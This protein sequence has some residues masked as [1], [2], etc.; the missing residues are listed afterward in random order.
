LKI[1]ERRRTNKERQR[2]FTELITETS[3]KRYGCV[4]AW[5]FFFFL[6]FFTNF[7]W[8]MLVQGAE[9]FILSLLPIYS[10]IRGGACHPPRRA[11]LVAFWWSFLMGPDGPNAEGHPPVWSVHPH[12]SYFAHFLSK[13]RETLRITWRR[14]LSI[15]TQ[16]TRI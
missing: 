1:D 12:F 10:K 13:H 2:T 3:W 5:I 16:L 15:S 11:E 6:P 8:N 14:V 4:S 9:P 7:K